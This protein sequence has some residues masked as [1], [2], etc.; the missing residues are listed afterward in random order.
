MMADSAV[1]LD[2]FKKEEGLDRGRPRFVEV[3][4]YVCKLTMF[5][6]AW[7]W[8]NKVKAA[9]LRAFGAQ[10]GVGLVLRPRVNIHMPW[11]LAIGNNC[12]IGERCE[13]LNLE[14]IIMDDHSALAH[15]VYLAAAGHDI[16]S[17]RMRYKNDGIRI[18][19]GAWIATRAY[20]GPGVTV[21]VNAV[22]AAGAVVTRDVPDG[23]VVGGSPARVLKE[24]VL[25]PE[26]Y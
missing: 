12:W 9:V 10:V 21:G 2:L 8:P 19:S 16:S 15:D 18:R 23:T 24:R 14:P 7:P 17:P 1:R 25:R 20:V 5:L 3:L 22:V 4:W 11:K 26:S 13:L 6:S